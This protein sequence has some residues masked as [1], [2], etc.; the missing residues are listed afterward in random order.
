MTDIMRLAEGHEQVVIAAG[1]AAGLRCVI[2]IHSTALGPSLGGTRFYPYRSGNEALADALRLSKAMT[3]KAA[4]AGLDI[5]G[6]KGVIIGDPL[7]DKT[8][9]VLRAYGQVVE[10]LGGRYYAACDVGTSP[11]DLAVVARETRFARGTDPAYGGSGDSAISTAAGVFLGLKACAQ[12]RFGTED[13]AGLRVAIQGAGKVGRRLAGLLHAEKVHLTVADIDPDAA[14]CV[15]ERYAADVTTPGEIHRADAD[16]Y[17]PNAMGGALD[18]RIIGELRAAVVAGAANNQLAEPGAGDRLRE[19]GIL[20]APDFV[21]SAGGLIQVV[22]E[23]HPGGPSEERAA[24]QV[25]TIPKRL[26][27]IF[28]MSERDGVNTDKAARRLA[29]DRIRAVSRIHASWTRPVP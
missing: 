18:E 5:G 23:L 24:A 22:D 9:A 12:F 10:S 21:I 25:E 3:Y 17:S 15:A 20:Y 8:E 14:A 6:G 16:I 7:R 13:L 26:A 2:A 11:S 4:A 27:G 19:K 1:E 28:E 29:E